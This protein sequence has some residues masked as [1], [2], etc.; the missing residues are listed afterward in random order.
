MQ[1]IAN[2]PMHF[3]CIRWFK[4]N[5]LRLGEV[6]EWFKAAVL[7]TADVKASVGSNPT[8]S[9]LNIYLMYIFVSTQK[10]LFWLSPNIIYYV[11][12]NTL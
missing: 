7:K 11:Q 1:G 10:F 12:L 9:V 6:A 3:K 8:L 4:S 5:I 2:P